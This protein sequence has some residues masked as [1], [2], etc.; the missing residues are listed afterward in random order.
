MDLLRQVEIEQSPSKWD[1]QSGR[2]SP[3]YQKRNISGEVAFY[4]SHRDGGYFSTRDVDIAL[5]LDTQQR[6][7]RNVKL[8]SMVHA[9]VL[10]RHPEIRG[11]YR[12]VGK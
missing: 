12:K 11:Y 3:V 1:I 5:Q 4:V 2:V 8:N 7:V 10:E 9:G 6:K